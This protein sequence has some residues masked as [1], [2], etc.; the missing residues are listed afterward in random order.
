MEPRA[1]V[2][3]LSELIEDYMEAADNPDVFIRP[4]YD[5][6]KT[7]LK[8]ISIEAEDKNNRL[9][10]EKYSIK[11]LDE[12]E[13]S[14]R[15][16]EV[17]SQISG[18]VDGEIDFYRHADRDDLIGKAWRNS[19]SVANFFRSR[20]EDLYI[21]IN[22]E[23]RHGQYGVVQI[24]EP[25]SQV[26]GLVVQ[27]DGDEDQEFRYEHITP[28]EKVSQDYPELIESFQKRMP[29]NRLS[30]FETENLQKFIE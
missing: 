29:D 5:S 6:T 25:P 27:V 17:S 4:F 3:N 16:S 1:R 23:E 12:S 2:E 13:N 7:G 28:K 14:I 18:K 24:L 15:Y 8:S 20:V 22:L 21:S 30:Y 9:W 11:G 26:S 10:D 19:I